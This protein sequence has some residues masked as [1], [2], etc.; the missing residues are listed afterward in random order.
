MLGGTPQ[1][2]TSQI[3]VIVPLPPLLLLLIIL[4]LLSLIV[5]W[6]KGRRVEA[7][8]L[9]NTFLL[10]TAILLIIFLR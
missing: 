9:L 1:E 7:L 8:T 4:G 5:L 6:R 10:I 3:R 2:Q